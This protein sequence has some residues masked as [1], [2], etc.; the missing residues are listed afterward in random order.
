MKRILASLLLLLMFLTNSVSTALSAPM[1]EPVRTD[2]TQPAVAGEYVV[3]FR[4]GLS[5]VERANI[6]ATSGGKTKLSL[7][8]L[9]ADLI[10]FPAL[11]RSPNAKAVEN[12]LT[13]LKNNPHVEYVEPNYIYQ[14]SYTPNDPDLGRQW[15]WSTIE[16]QAGWDTT[17]GSSSV[18]IAVVDTGVQSNHPDLDAKLVAGYD[19]VEGDTMPDDGNGHGTHVAGTA[20]AETNNSTGGAG[21]CPNCRVMPVRVLDSGGSGTMANVANGIIWAADNGAKVINLSLGG[22]S[23]STLENAVIYAWNKGAFLACAAGNG[24]TSS[25]TSAYPAAYNNCFSVAATTVNDEKSSFSNYGNWV[26]AAAPGSDIYST[27]MG[28]SYKTLNG[29]SMAAPHVAG[30]AGLLASQG[31][32]NQQIWDRIMSTAD[33]IEG[34]GNY[35]TAGRINVR[36]AVTNDPNAPP[37]PPDGGASD[38]QNGGFEDGVDPWILYS[39]AGNALISDYRPH[40]GTFSSW[41]GGYNYAKDTVTQTVTVPENGWLTYWWYLSTKEK[42]SKA[43]DIFRVK[44]Y[45]TSGSLLA[46]LKTRSNMDARGAWY[47]D[48]LSLANYAGMTV[49][50]EFSVTTDSIIPSHFWVDDIIVQ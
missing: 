39:K 27:Y 5:A 36:R 1:D 7:A 42:T 37:P 16:A 33:M 23:S 44:V 9:N 2:I 13:A 28:S 14:V 3:K 6:A 30:L 11:K 34:T 10:E 22:G 49:K 25:T 8:A 15:A 43:Y 4:P 12:M 41:L 35:W 38:L 24:N 21:T 20:A 48:T 40:T 45:S 32:T 46:T 47:Q 26:E 17:Q 29:T 31:L 19:F 50:I 18:I